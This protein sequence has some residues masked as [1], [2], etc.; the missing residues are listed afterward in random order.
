MGQNWTIWLSAKVNVEVGVDLQAALHIVHVYLE[1]VGALVHQ[2]RIE[3]LVPI[4]DEGV[5]DIQP[6][7]I[8]AAAATQVFDKVWQHRTA[9]RE[10]SSQWLKQNARVTKGR[11][12]S[13]V[14]YCSLSGKRLRRC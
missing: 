4:G 8:Q 3:L 9:E 6:L 12:G 13:R 11:M 2:V 1:K 5:G 14:G 10:Q 7:A